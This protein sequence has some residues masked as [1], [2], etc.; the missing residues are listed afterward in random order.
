MS[1]D[2]NPDLAITEIQ[3]VTEDQVVEQIER[4][5]FDVET[6]IVAGAAERFDRDKASLTFG[7]ILAEGLGTGAAIALLWDGTRWLLKKEDGSV[8]LVGELAGSLVYSLSQPAWETFLLRV[9]RRL[10]GYG[11]FNQSELTS[12]QNLLS[13]AYHSVV[14]GTI[15]GTLYSMAKWLS[16][17]PGGH[18]YGWEVGAITSGFFALAGYSFLV[19]AYGYQ[20]PRLGETESTRWTEVLSASG[21]QMFFDFFDFKHWIENRG[22][23][24]ISFVALAGWIGPFINAVAGSEPSALG[25]WGTNIALLTLFLA[26][27][28]VVVALFAKG[29]TLGVQT[30]RAVQ[31][32]LGFPAP[33]SE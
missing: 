24:V 16:E 13:K 26:Q 21:K 32:R 12:V 22:P 7:A 27:T 3:P 23:K 1:T 17:N 33:R 31:R 29:A 6:G 28:H 11:K 20:L 9:I 8:P 19:N 2:D 14:G 30:N 4:V 18:Q 10:T 25:F 15:V 5:P